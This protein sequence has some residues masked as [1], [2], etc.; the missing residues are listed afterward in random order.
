MTEEQALSELERV[1]A[2]RDQL[3]A[4]VRD[5]RERLRVSRMVLGT[6]SDTVL[7]GKGTYSVPWQGAE[8]WQ[9]EGGR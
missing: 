1:A 3:A 8:G 4:E 6:L 5:L 2:E 7:S 9:K